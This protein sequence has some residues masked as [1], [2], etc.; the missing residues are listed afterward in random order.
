MP[1]K[2]PFCHVSSL[3]GRISVLRSTDKVTAG[4][5]TRQLLPPIVKGNEA[6]LRSTDPQMEHVAAS[7]RRQA[8]QESEIGPNYQT[9]LMTL[10]LGGLAKADEQLWKSLLSV[11][12]SNKR[13]QKFSRYQQVSHDNAMCWDSSLR[14]SAS[15]L[16]RL[17]PQPTSRVYVSTIA[18]HF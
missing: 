3:L 17:L 12:E 9:K 5:R 15:C 8:G 14:D 13:P 2:C 4:H 7:S 11:F 10:T 16:E 1:W 6:V 18:K